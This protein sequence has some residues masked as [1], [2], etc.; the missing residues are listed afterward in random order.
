MASWGCLISLS[1]FVYDGPA[2]RIGFV[3]RWQHDNFR[4]FFSAANGWGT[5]QQT[6]QQNS[7]SNSIDV[8]Y[9]SVR[10]QDL[11]FELPANNRHTDAKIEIQGRIIPSKV[12]QT[13]QRVDFRLDEPVVMNSGETLIATLTWK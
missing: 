10:L 11:V 12:T 7:Q 3:P 13:G 6:R 4:A 9:G 2:G 1:G 5:L 8:K